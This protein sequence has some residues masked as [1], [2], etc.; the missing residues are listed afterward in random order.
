MSQILSRG[1]VRELPE[2]I[3]QQVRGLKVREYIEADNRRTLW[4]AV[5]RAKKIYP[6]RLYSVT[7]QEVGY[8]CLRLK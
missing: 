5:Y 8:R 1:K 2:T 7:Q 6:K 3:T 4:T